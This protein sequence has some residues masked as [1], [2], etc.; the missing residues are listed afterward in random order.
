MKEQKIKASTLKFGLLLVP[1]PSLGGMNENVGNYFL[2]RN[3]GCMQGCEGRLSVYFSFSRSI[4]PCLLGQVSSYRGP[5]SVFAFLWSCLWW[6]RSSPMCT[7]CRLLECPFVIPGSM[8]LNEPV[9][10][11]GQHSKSITAC[12]WVPHISV[13]C[14]LLSDDSV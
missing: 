7:F 14:L 1:V 10:C 3:N 12:Q 6:G 4:F 11:P 2:L 5:N 13:R 8:G 9:L